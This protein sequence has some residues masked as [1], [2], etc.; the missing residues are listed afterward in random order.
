MWVGEFK[1]R[2]AQD[3]LQKMVLPK[4]KTF[5][6]LL[7]ITRL[8]AVTFEKRHAKDSV[9]SYRKKSHSKTYDSL[10]ISRSG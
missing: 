8:T 3:L 10:V 2:P 7:K 6:F 9:M 4:S 5:E 1:K